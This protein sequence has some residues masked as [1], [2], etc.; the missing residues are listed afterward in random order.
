MVAV[1][2]AATGARMPPFGQVFPGNRSALAT[3]LAGI[4]GVYQHDCASGACSPGNTEGLELTV[5]QHH[6]WMCSSPLWR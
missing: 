2:F 3:A 6:G 5:S 4:V 1:Q